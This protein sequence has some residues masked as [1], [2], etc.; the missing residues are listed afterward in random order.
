MSTKRLFAIIT[1]VIC[2]ILFS[3]FPVIFVAAKDVRKMDDNFCPVE[4]YWQ[5]YFGIKI[6]KASVILIDTSNF[7][8][9]D[10]GKE[11]AIWVEKWIRQFPPFQQISIHALPKS[12]KLDSEIIK[13][14]RCVSW[15]K[16]TAPEWLTGGLVAERDFRKKFLAKI[17]S[18]FN[19]AINLPEAD[20]SP[21]IEKLA[22]LKAEGI[23][24]V[25]LVSDMLQSTN[26]EKHYKDG[27]RCDSNCP[28]IKGM[29]LNVY[30][31]KRENVD[32][33]ANH[34]QR[35]EYLVGKEI[36][37]HSFETKREMRK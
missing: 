17:Q 12:E 32:R 13:D 26:I 5:K 28:D 14:Y 24:S 6:G 34:R 11:A 25:F 29:S 9:K 10:D 3:A 15:N 8:L 19:E 22:A 16:G 2:I 21:I 27:L 31:I 23:N 1:I 35:W 4:N 30:Y 20:Q 33:P 37:W 7:I 18:E 36:T